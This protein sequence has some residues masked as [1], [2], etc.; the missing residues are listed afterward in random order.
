MGTGFV[1]KTIIFWDITPCNLVEV[2]TNFGKIC[3]IP[4]QGRKTS[5]GTKKVNKN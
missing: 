5:K 2:Y 4:L 1:M 3:Y